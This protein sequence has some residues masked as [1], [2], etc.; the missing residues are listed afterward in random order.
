MKKNLLI[1]FALFSVALSAQTNYALSFNG[2]TGYAN[3]GAAGNNTIRSV[4]FWFKP[5]A[6]ITSAISDPA[7]TFISRHDAAVQHEFVFFIYGTDWSNNLGQLCFGFRDNGV[8]HNVHSNSST[9]TANTWYHV[10]GTIDANAGMKLYINGVLQTM[11]DASATMP[12]VATT[13]MTTLG[14]WSSAMTRY[15]PGRMDEVRFWSRAITQTEIQQKMCLSLTPANETGLL[16]YWQMNE[17]IGTTIFDATANAYNGTLMGATFVQDS[18]CNNATTSINK[19]ANNNQITLY[20]NPAQ[21]NFTIETNNSI[22]Q[23]LQIFD[24]NGNLVLSQTINGTT[25]VDASNLSQGVY[26]ISLTNNEGVINKR[27]VI[28]K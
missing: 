12:I 15:F 8:D 27:L 17:G 2:T 23:T 10:C 25:S 26:N 6:T 22:K 16:D 1:L 5:N 21:N 24:V 20:P 11:T 28:V 9:W 18:A 4:E 7:Y 13:D 3:L 19:L 14:E